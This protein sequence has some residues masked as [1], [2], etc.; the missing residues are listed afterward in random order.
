MR[1]REVR[2][3]PAPLSGG[4]ELLPLVFLRLRLLV[5]VGQLGALDLQALARQ[6]LPRRR[7]KRR[8]RLA[9]IRLDAAQSVAQ[10][11]PAL[12]QG[13]TDLAPRLARLYKPLLSRARAQ[14][15]GRLRL[16]LLV[17]AL[18]GLMSGQ[19]LAHLVFHPPGFVFDLFEAATIFQ[20][21]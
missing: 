7:T 12:L 2:V 20:V 9:A 19:L 5:L 11:P 4:N 10:L 17:V 13:V 16:A 8:R 3:V 15:P 21:P 1:D 14:T 6:A 18:L